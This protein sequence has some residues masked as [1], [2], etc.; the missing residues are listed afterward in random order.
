MYNFDEVIDRR[1]TNSYK[2]NVADNEL[3]MWVADM[4]F[5]TAPCVLEALQH[6]VDHGVFGYAD[7]PDEWYAA[8]QYWWKT[9]H[10]F[11]IQKDRN[12]HHSTKVYHAGRKGGGTDAGI[13]YVFQ[14]HHK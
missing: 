7:L 1:N 6:R 13:Q 14:L 4:D 12:F 10:N 11:E 2:W 3:A 8:Y 9:Y 5:K